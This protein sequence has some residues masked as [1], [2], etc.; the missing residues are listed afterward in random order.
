LLFEQGDVPLPSKRRFQKAYLL[1]YCTAALGQAHE[2]KLVIEAFG[3][4][5]AL[6]PRMSGV[7]SR[8]AAIE[9]A[10]LAI[11]VSDFQKEFVVPPMFCKPFAY[12]PGG[13][14]EIIVGPSAIAC[15]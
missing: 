8:R 9:T 7:G 15:A 1:K 6:M 13:L 4:L 11:G 2:I 12:Q 14:F 3:L 10:G 5:P